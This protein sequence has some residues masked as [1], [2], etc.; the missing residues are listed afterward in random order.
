MKNI[1]A[2]ILIVD[3]EAQTR[4]ILREH[5]SERMNCDIIEASDGYS[6]LAA[7][8]KNSFDLILSDIKMP[9]ISGH[10][11]IEKIRA[12]GKNVPV[13]VLTKWDSS[14]VA[15]QVKHSGAEYIPKPFSLK[16][17]RE[18]V[19]EKLKAAGKFSPK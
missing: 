15:D 6:A 7:V 5:L 17:V 8:K 3:D 14:Q 19:E 4:K 16:I 2:K 9:G 10:E 13:I 18:K 1:K 11:V 12:V